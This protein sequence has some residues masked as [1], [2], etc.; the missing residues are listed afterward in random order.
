MRAL[1]TA[2]AQSVLP[3]YRVA[4]VGAGRYANTWAR[5]YQTNPRC[6]RDRGRRRYR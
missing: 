6:E 5:A 1:I 4:M 2:A 3:V